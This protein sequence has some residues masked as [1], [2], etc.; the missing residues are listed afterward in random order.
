MRSNHDGRAT[1]G[2]GNAKAILAPSLSPRP[3][4][5]PA[6][7]DGSSRALAA[8]A[9]VAIAFGVLVFAMAWSIA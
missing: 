7:L 1:C 8:L 3:T 2:S 6:K 9:I 4:R 5:D